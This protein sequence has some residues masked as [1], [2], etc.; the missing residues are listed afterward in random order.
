MDHSLASEIAKCIIAAWALAVLAQLLGQP[1]IL[2]YLAAGFACGPQGLGLVQADEH[3]TVIAEIGLS[4]LLFMIGLE[5]DLRKMLRAGRVITL[6]STVQILGGCVLSLLVFMGWGFALGHGRLDALYLAVATSLSS[7]VIIVKVLYDKRELDTLPGR[8]TLGILVLQDLF[9][10]LFLALRP[11]LQDG[12]FLVL[13]LALFKVVV[14]VAFAFVASKYFLPR[15]FKAMA[16]A[17]ELLLVGALAWCFI[18]AAIALELGL[19]REMGALIAG[20]ALSTFPYTLDVAAKVTSLRDFFVTLFFVA[21]G[22]R[23]PPPTL[24]LLLGALLLGGLVVASRFVTVFSVLHRLHQGHRV[25]LLPAINLSQISEFSLVILLLGQQSGHIAQHTLD[26]AAYTFVLLAAASSYG[27][28][29]SDALARRL[30]ALLRK[31]G[32][33]DLDQHAPSESGDGKPAPRILVLGFFTTASSLVTEIERT[34]PALLAEIAV[35][36]FNPN[37]LQRLRQRGIKVIYG[38]ISKRETLLH[39]GVGRAEVLVCTLPDS[40]LKGTT[41]VVHVRQLREINPAA[42]IIVTSDSFAQ[43]DELYRAGADY[44][45]VPRITEATELCTV[46]A[47][48]MDNGLQPRREEMDARLADRNEVLP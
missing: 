46:L 4:L 31:V 2:A 12:S 20:V 22:M 30:G 3:I 36:D 35:I 23:I 11:H 13:G 26:L 16:R 32:V 48:A 9:A 14:L 33:P 38:D 29:A 41:N 21:L 6:V 44:V 24:D 19:S 45:R 42:R 7:T 10:I 18:L 43:I 28:A 27:I 5:I 47:Q 34:Q 1:L 15:L 39:A 37:V 17:P 25:S 40:I 8:L